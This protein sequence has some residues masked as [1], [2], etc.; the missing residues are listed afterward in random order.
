MSSDNQF[1][2][3]GPASLGLQTNSASINVGA[4]IAGSEVGVR[5]HCGFHTKQTGTAPLGNLGF[6]HTKGV[7]S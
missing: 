5:G 3:L 2:A 7:F 6:Q 4:D 1:T